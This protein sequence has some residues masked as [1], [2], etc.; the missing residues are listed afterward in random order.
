VVVRAAG[1]GERAVGD[2]AGIRLDGDVGLEPVL[3][4]VHGLVRVPCLGI[5]H[6]DHPVRGDALGD[7]PAGRI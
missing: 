5:D 1:F 7:L 6:A 4:A 2:Q 3:A